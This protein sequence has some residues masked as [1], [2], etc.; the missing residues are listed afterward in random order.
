MQ[1]EEVSSKGARPKRHVRP[2]VYL[3]DYDLT[4]TRHRQ[5][6]TPTMPHAAEESWRG[7]TSDAVR[8]SPSP[9]DRASSPASQYSWRVIDEWS[10]AAFNGECSYEKQQVKVPSQF[11]APMPSI[12][13]A[14]FSP[15]HR[16]WEETGFQSSPQTVV[17]TSDRPN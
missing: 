11:R 4:A 2:P 17:N 13:S 9:S 8:I 16:P 6:A 12:Q 7:G 14:Q 10:L 3:E 15:F 1:P 5:V